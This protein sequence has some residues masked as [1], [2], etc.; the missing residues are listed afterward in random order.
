MCNVREYKEIKRKH[1]ATNIVL[2]ILCI[3]IFAMVY[4]LYQH[5]NVIDDQSHIIRAN[6]DQIQKMN[7]MIISN[8]EINVNIMYP[9]IYEKISEIDQML[10]NLNQEVFIGI[11]EVE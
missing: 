7:E 1:T 4:T 2:S 10:D 9:E 5:K 11:E 3:L 8:K 6:M